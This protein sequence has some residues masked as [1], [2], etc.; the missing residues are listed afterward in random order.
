MMQATTGWFM[1]YWV[2]YFQT[3]IDGSA[4]GVS[5]LDPGAALAA[6]A[7]ADRQVGDGRL[8]IDVLRCL[9]MS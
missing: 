5:W 6:S 9:E 1:G 4:F 7:A 2:P 8:G 3:Q